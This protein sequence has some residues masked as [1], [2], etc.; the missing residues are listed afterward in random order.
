MSPKLEMR[1]KLYF[2]HQTYDGNINNMYFRVVFVVM[3]SILVGCI[4][5]R[6]FNFCEKIVSNFYISK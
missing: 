5:F 1:E 2:E 4:I 3:S 6:L